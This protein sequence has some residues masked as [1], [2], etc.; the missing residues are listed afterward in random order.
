ML[1]GGTGNDWLDAGA[2]N[3]RLTGGDGNDTLTGGPGADTLDGGAGNDRLDGGA[4]NDIL[5]GGAGSDVFVFNG[6]QDTIQDFTNGQDRIWL[7]A[8]LWGGTPPPVARLLEDAT[9]T[10]TGVILALPGGATLDIR[11]VFDTTL[12][13]DDFLFV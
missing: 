7:E 9:H 2:G 8:D 10:D 3:D 12:L 6:G 1:D 4:G 5:L 13:M 11:G